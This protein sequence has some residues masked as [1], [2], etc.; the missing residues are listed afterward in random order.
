M[1]RAS[2]IEE[3]G[4]V[5]QKVVFVAVE[6]K[7]P[8]EI[9]R[10]LDSLAVA[11]ESEESDDES[12][13]TPEFEQVS[14]TSGGILKTSPSREVPKQPKAQRKNVAMQAILRQQQQQRQSEDDGEERK[15]VA[16]KTP[17]PEPPLSPPQQSPVAAPPRLPRPLV[18]QTVMPSLRPALLT[19]VPGNPDPRGQ[20]GGYGG[21]EQPAAAAPFLPIR[22]LSS[23]TIQQPRR[24]QMNAPTAQNFHQNL[25]PRPPPPQPQN[26][27]AGQQ[28]G[29]L[30]PGQPAPVPM[31][32]RFSEPPPNFGGPLN[33]DPRNTWP[34][35]S[36][37]A[38]AQRFPAAQNPAMSGPA[39]SL[40][41]GPSWQQQQQ[42]HNM[43]QSGPSALE[44]LLNQQRSDNQ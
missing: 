38:A 31:P 21:A 29:Y 9:L 11:D 32:P 16:F 3:E 43:F 15:Q 7:I 26:P 27:W 44:R 37:L 42:Q 2:I 4:A 34:P 8:D 33:L 41:S 36:P 19:G 23:S 35:P 17:T 22:P 25:Q 30:R 39:Y 20:R 24:P 5:E 6:Q 13:P 14:E 40:F 18:A 12:E 28:G 1:V 10:E